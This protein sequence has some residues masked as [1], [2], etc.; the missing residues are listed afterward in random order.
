[1]ND[2]Y[3]KNR[4]S[5]KSYATRKRH[6]IYIQTK[7]QVPDGEGGFTDGYTSGSLV[8]ADVTPM[9][10]K[11]VFEY[12]GIQ[13]EATHLLTVDGY[14]TVPETARILFDGRYFEILYSEN[15]QERSFEKVITCREVR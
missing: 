14:V 1:M 3:A 15:L 7:T 5:R 13:V 10:A 11:Q 12:R 6:P 2:Q 9:R 8:W 4:I